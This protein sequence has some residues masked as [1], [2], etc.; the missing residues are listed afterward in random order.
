MIPYFSKGQRPYIIIIYLHLI[1]KDH[2]NLSNI[3]LLLPCCK[4]QIYN[5]YHCYR[6]ILLQ[7]NNHLNIVDRHYN[8]IIILTRV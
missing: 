4:Y 5:I 2:V 7:W 8:G 1:L 6:C 3:I